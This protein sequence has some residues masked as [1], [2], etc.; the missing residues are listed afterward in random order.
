MPLF[1]EIAAELKAGQ[2]FEFFK[3]MHPLLPCALPNEGRLASNVN[4]AARRS[5]VS[6]CG[7]CQFLFAPRCGLLDEVMYGLE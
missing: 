1:V 6:N 5:V 2:D 7:E 4:T 3:D